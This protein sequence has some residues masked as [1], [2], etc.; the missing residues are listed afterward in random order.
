MVGFDVNK[1]EK[2][3]LICIADAGGGKYFSA[4]SAAQ[5][6]DALTEVKK[7]V[8]EKIEVKK[9][10]RRPESKRKNEQPASG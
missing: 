1:E 9:P 5:L 8:V 10:G 3:Q 2:D 4:N 7:A 6:K